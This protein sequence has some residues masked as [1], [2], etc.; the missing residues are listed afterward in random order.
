MIKL[1]NRVDHWF[2]FGATRSACS[3]FLNI[4]GSQLPPESCNALLAM[5]CGWSWLAFGLVEANHR[6]RGS[7]EAAFLE[8]LH[9]VSK[10]L[11]CW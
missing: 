1:L 11:H 10:Q 8:A 7:S 2:C 3:R 9:Y 6:G 4:F 5:V